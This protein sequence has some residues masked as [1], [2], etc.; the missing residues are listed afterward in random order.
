MLTTVIIGVLRYPDQ[1]ARHPAVQ[2]GV[3][4]F[5]VVTVQIYLTGVWTALLMS[6]YRSRPD[7]DASCPVASTRRY[8]RFLS[9]ISRALLTLTALADLSMLLG[10][11]RRWQVYRPAGIGTI[12]PLL[13][14]VA[15]LLLIVVVALRMG[16]G[17]FRLS[18]DSQRGGA[19]ATTDRDDDRLWKAGL[20][21]V[22]R[23]D[24]AVVVGRR[25]GVGWTLNW[26]QPTSWLAIAAVAAVPI[27]LAVIRAAAGL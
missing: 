2:A 1:A 5:A 6:V 11:L 15:G 4:V 27:G 19:K 20:F 23:N 13:P 12:L 7:I 14:V 10:A 9:A 25:F 17:G 21:Y 18:G 16:Q 26:G 22:N 24:P 3:S 8:R